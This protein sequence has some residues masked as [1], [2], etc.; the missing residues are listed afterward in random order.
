MLVYAVNDEMSYQFATLCRQQVLRCRGLENGELAKKK[1]KAPMILIANKSD[2]ADE[3]RVSSIESE[4][5]ARKWGIPFKETS[6]KLFCNVKESFAELVREV[7]RQGVATPQQRDGA[8][9]SGEMACS[10][11]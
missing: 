11:S 3:A 4:E 2:L 7:R 9:S 1:M 6:A 10:L 8:N 5:Q